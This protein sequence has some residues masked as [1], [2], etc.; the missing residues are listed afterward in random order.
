[1]D[2]VMEVSL[3]KAVLQMVSYVTAVSIIACFKTIVN[4]R[5]I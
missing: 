2:V 5:L 3:F 1:M 4:F